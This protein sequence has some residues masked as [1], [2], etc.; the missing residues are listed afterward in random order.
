MP[1]FTNYGTGYELDPVGVYPSWVPSGA[2]LPTKFVLPFRDPVYNQGQSNNSPV[3]AVASLKSQEEFKEHRAYYNFN[4]NTFYASVKGIDT[5]TNEGSNL[6]SCVS[7]LTSYGYLADSE[8]HK[9]DN[10]YPFPIMASFKLVDLSEIQDAI[11]SG[12]PVMLGIEM[13]DGFRVLTSSVIPEPLG[14][15]TTAQAF[16]VYGWDDDK[17]CEASTGALYVKNSW[18]KAWGTGGFSWLPYSY[19]TAYQF[20]AWC[21]TD[22]TDIGI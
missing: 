4:V 21:V 8:V 2:T 17:E 7:V 12:R 1:D 6:T 15:S 19:L 10:P 13:D 11:K 5:I 3:H 14:V 20:D 18:G 22:A 16:V 9:L